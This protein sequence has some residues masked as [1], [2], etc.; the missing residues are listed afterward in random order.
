MR[1]KLQIKHAYSMDN[2][3]IF[4]SKRHKGYAVI[5]TVDE[6]DEIRTEWTKMEKYKKENDEQNKIDYIIEKIIRI[7]CVLTFA[8]I[9]LILLD[10]V[11]SQYSI[12]GIR[13]LLIGGVIIMLS[14][15]FIGNCIER[16]IEKNVYKFH[17]AEHMVINAYIKLKRVPSLEEI[18]KYSRFNN[19]C[20][21]NVTTQIVISLTLMFF[22]TFFN[23]P[24]YRHIGMIFS[25]VIV[26][27]LL[28][29]G[30]LNFLQKFTTDVPTDKELLVAISG[31]NVWIEN[32][33]MEKENLE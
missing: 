24:L 17:S 23:N 6:F 32:E 29:C 20:G 9:F 19:Y 31:M 16:K 3:I 7:L 10:W 11:I 4:Y 21:T 1:T 14:T 33:K 12:L 18:R 25:N 13:F 8:I 27:I 2:G 15:F 28:E 30:F 26:L 22:C 5:S